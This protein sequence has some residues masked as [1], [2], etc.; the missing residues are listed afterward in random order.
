LA[1]TTMRPDRQ[2]DRVLQAPSAA[3]TV[4]LRP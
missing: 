2:T 1:W 4:T 3:M